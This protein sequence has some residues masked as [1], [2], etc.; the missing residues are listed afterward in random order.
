[1]SEQP[2]PVPNDHPPIVDLVVADLH[3]R[4]AHGIRE[5]GI[6]LQPWNG[7]D[8]L[9][10]LYEEL[11]DAAQYARQDLHERATLAPL[12]DELLRAAKAVVDTVKPDRTDEHAAVK[13][14]SAALGAYGFTHWDTRLQPP[15]PD[16]NEGYDHRRS[17]ELARRA[18]R[19]NPRDEGDRLANSDEVL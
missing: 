15:I 10:D 5:Y 12:L 8:P 1:M 9:V 18:M 13:R 6:P 3:R 7:R 4:K 17:M 2:A 14:L 16:S 19:T 11:L